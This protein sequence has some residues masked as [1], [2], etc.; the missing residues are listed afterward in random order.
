MKRKV[1]S[2]NALPAN[3][4]ELR[5]FSF[6]LLLFVLVVSDVDELVEGFLGSNR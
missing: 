3:E 5:G 1:I 4:S 6:V 2:Q